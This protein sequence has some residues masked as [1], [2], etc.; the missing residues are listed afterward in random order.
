MNE[1]K[2]ITR[3]FENDQD[4]IGFKLF[5]ESNIIKLN[6]KNNN[7][8]DNNQIEFNTQSL[9]TKIINYSDVYIEVEIELE[10]PFDDTDQGK[11]SIP[12][13]VALK[14]SYEIV[15]NLKIQLNNV[16]ISNESNIHRSNLVN[17]IL[18]NSY[19]SP[20]S[21]RNIRKSNQDT[22]NIDDKKFITKATYFNK[23][24]D[25]D[26]IKPHYITFKIPIFLKDISD[27][28]RK[29]ELIQFGE[30]NI[31]I[32]LIDKI[33]VTS[34]EGCTYEIKNAHLYTEEVKL[35]DSDNIKYLKMLDNKFT[36]KINFMEN[37]TLTFDSKLKEV[38]EDFAINN[39]RNSD[40]VFIYGI[41]NVDKVGLKNDL[42]SVGIE[43][44]YLNIDNI[45]FENPIPNDI[46][47][48]NILKYKSNHSDNFI[49][50]YKEFL[51]NYRIYCFNVNRQTQNDS[52][53]KFMN[54]ITNIESDSSTVYIVWKNYSVIEME[55]NKNGL[56]IYKTY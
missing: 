24:E 13:V 30:F 25:E 45:R 43:N 10:F 6:N 28:F 18:N 14:N 39:I 37:Y 31:N 34:R 42:P 19:N 54:I 5:K 16:I 2:T 35:T 36:K 46:S 44:P 12:D 7:N 27:Y 29:I 32:Q 17:F 22:L 56:N 49:I 21:Y 8:Y 55:Y 15:K 52:N 48:Y 41:L 1:Y 38:N 23:K 47:A 51:E 20:S 53:N 26:V 33:F 9:S 3:L 11:K 50:T 40:S 4:E